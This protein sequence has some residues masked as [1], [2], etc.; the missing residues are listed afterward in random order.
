MKRTITLSCLALLSSLCAIAQDGDKAVAL[1]E[2]VVRAAKV[3]GKV[4]G[5]AIYP[6]EA[7][8]TASVNG[9]GMLQKLSLPNIRVDAAEHTISAIDN[10]GGVQVRINGIVAGRQE[11]MSLNPK[12]VVRIDFVNRPGVRYGEGTAYVI[13]IITRRAGQG[14][15]FGTDA[16]A[17]LTA[18]S[19]NGMAYGKWSAGKSE[20]SL[21]YGFGGHRLKGMKGTET[22][23]YTLNDGSVHTIVRDDVATQRKQSG[24]DVKLTYNWADST[25]CVFQASLSGSWHRE[26]GN[27]SIKAV[28]DGPGRYTATSREDGSGCTPV[29]DLYF[30][31]QFTPRQSVTANAVG[32][33]ISTKAGTYY[34]EGSPYMY[35]VDGRSASILSEVIYENRLK[36]F[37]LSAGLNYRFKHTRNTYT[38]DAGALAAMSHSTV[39]AF[40]E[41]K[42]QARGVDYQLGAGA[43][44]IHYMQ[45]SHN[46]DYWT[47]RP[48][49]SLAYSF[50][51]SMQLSYTFSVSERVSGIAMVSDAAIR[52]NSMEWTV[53]N[54]GLKPNRELEHTLRLS[55]NTDRW[56]AFVD[57]YCKKCVR[58]SMALYERTADNRFVYTQV[59][60]KA[61]DVLQVSAYAGFWA[62]PEKLQLTANGGMYRCFNFGNDYTHCNTSWFCQGSVEAFLGNLTLVAQADNGFSFLEGENKGYNGGTTALQAS[63]RL[64]G[65]Q[66][67]LTWINPFCGKYKVY[68]S[69]I[70]NRNLHKH[71]VG[72]DNDRS[73]GLML[74][75][76]WRVSHG[77]SRQAIRKTIDLKD[78]D[79]G[80]MKSSS[81]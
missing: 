61:I 44:Y 42:G 79:S 77:K 52:S 13:D 56:Q 73:N 1:G 21:S 51:R 24:H 19:G 41:I 27:Y 38:G 46:Y 28:A 68:G 35:K 62:V 65:W 45:G 26:P 48:K 15:T 20:L 37:V 54:P 14:Y 17:A 60:Q 4:D 80:I 23:D 31:R 72:F 74:N 63:Y 16:T 10:K 55:R 66:L 8:R 36:P 64:G 5:L 67:S 2:V 40:G 75:V 7:Q 53:G 30:F 25:A 6:T 33:Y 57:G 76:A 47:F 39:Y 11:L 12:T 3:V 81:R 78:S 58:P 18:L 43:S 34:D 9:Y 59:N 29:A 49:V 32:T 22:A 69:E 71:A 70:L 50:A